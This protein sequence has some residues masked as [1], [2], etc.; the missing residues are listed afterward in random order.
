MNPNNLHANPQKQY[1]YSFFSIGFT[2][3]L[4][5][6]LNLYS[7]TNAFPDVHLN[8]LYLKQI[9]WFFCSFILGLALSFLKPKNFFHQAY[10]LYGL[11]ILL[12]VLV[13]V[14]GKKSFGAK[15][16]IDLG[17]MRFQ[18]SE[19]MKITLSLTLAR[20]FSQ[21]FINQRLTLKT[22]LFP[23]LI[24][25]IPA[26]LIALQ[27]DLGTGLLLALILSS[28]ILFKGIEFK[29]FLLIALVGVC[30]AGGLYKFGLKEYQRKRITTF[31]NPSRDA[32][33]SGYNALQSK[34][35]IGSGRLFGKGYRKSSQTSLQFLPENHT[36]FVFSVFNE[37]HGFFGS[38]ILISLYLLLFFRFIVIAITAAHLFDSFLMIG[39]FSIFFWHTF[40]NMGMV[41]GLLP[42]V[43]LPL[44]FMSYGGS[45]LLTFGICL[46]IATAISNRRNLFS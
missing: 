42:V 33:G 2:I 14:I 39:L 19:L 38:L 20:F 21:F 46:G 12:L 3:F 24:T 1:D 11:N 16:W 6:I 15:R 7:T 29:S 25:L 18:P 34:I 28:L 41:M 37:E 23:I 32:R 31:L 36:D 40:I 4:V 35:A 13:F 8:Q 9:L 30:L 17:L 10:R 43:G 45:S 5:G 27:P 44:P 22:I 26:L